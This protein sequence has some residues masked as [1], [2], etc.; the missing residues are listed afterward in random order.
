MPL[1]FLAALKPFLLPRQSFQQM[2]SHRVK[3][4]TLMLEKCFPVLRTQHRLPV[5]VTYKAKAESSLLW[6]DCA[7]GDN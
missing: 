7:L 4:D 2:S 5:V 6:N 3:Q 1:R